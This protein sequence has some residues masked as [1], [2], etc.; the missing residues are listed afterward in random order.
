MFTESPIQIQI[1]Q[2]GNKS[3]NFTVYDIEFLE[4]CDY[5]NYTCNAYI[6][7]KSKKS[8]ELEL[9]IKTQ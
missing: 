4:I 8:P 5:I 7:A 2:K 3:Y 9:T 6:E 1:K